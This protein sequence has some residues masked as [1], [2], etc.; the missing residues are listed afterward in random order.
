MDKVTREELLK[1]IN[2][3][4]KKISDVRFS[5]WKLKSTDKD[6]YDISSQI[7]D[8]LIELK[9]LEKEMNT[10]WKNSYNICF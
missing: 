3:I 10:A 9:E 8:V 7:C 4:S 1:E 6:I 2:N 5:I